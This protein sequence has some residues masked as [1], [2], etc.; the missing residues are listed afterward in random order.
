MSQA[1]DREVLGDWS[2]LKGSRYHLVYALWL[3]LRDRASGVHFFEGNDLLA[4][5]VVPPM[6]TDG[7]PP[8]AIPLVAAAGAEDLWIQLKCTRE[9]WTVTNLLGENL[10]FNFVC[11]SFL[12]E[13]R[14][15]SWRVLLVTEGVVRRDEI[16]DF[17]DNPGSRPTLNGRLEEVV[18]KASGALSDPGWQS[19]TAAEIRDR[20]VGILRHLA[21]TEPLALDTL[22]A[23][24]QIELT[25]ACPDRQRTRRLAS[26]LIGAMLEDAS[27]EPARARTY[28]ASWVN[29][30]A[31][32]AIKSAK[33]F[34]TDVVA[35][36]QLAAEDAAE[37]A[38]GTPHDESRHVPRDAA[39][40]RLRQFLS[41]QEV[42][43]LL[44][45]PSGAGKSATLAHWAVTGLAGRTRMLLKGS[46]L[47]P[48]TT[49]ARL[50][51]GYFAPYTD[52]E[53]RDVEFLRKIAE[54]SR[55]PGRGP[56]IVVVDDLSA[57]ELDD[58][59][60]W[61]TVADLA[62]A[63]GRVGGKLV[64]SCETQAWRL[65]HPW[66]RIPQGTLFDPERSLGEPPTNR[67]YE[68]G[69]LTPGELVEILS[70]RSGPASERQARR[71]ARLLLGPGHVPLRNP[72]L[73]TRYLELHGDELLS[74]SGPPG[75]VDI[76][77]LL[78][79]VVHVR[80]ERCA[81]MLRTDDATLESAFLGLVDRLWE[82]RVVG[83]T[84]SEAVNLLDERLPDDGKHALIAFRRHGLLASDSPI[85]ILDGAIADYLFATRLEGRI[86]EGFA[87]LSELDPERD[88]TVVEALT[89]RTLTLLGA[90]RGPHGPGRPSQR[91]DR[92]GARPAGSRRDEPR[93][94]GLARPPGREPPPG[95]RW[96]RG[97]RD[98][99]REGPTG[100]PDC[101]QHVPRCRSG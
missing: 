97:P 11:N 72:Y 53:W 2:N 100:V 8:P 13:A 86:R 68:L 7:T 76:D 34:D 78:E 83:V 26:L 45:G 23:E 39:L 9:P 28:D 88:A 94:G 48:G 5:P 74:R 69:V 14:G 36:C 32:T 30:V 57:D 41:A 24:V 62:D 98:A 58:R 61:S 54:I 4:R 93:P 3:I 27:E 10:L 31:G 89:R 101:H 96:L 17:A 80:L 6:L 50:V 95:H 87:R 70:R 38:L 12:S 67:S 43:F 75:P 49:L 92:E 42:V 90:R 16:L 99:G 82:R 20:A 51:A 84:H 44:I 15:R 35:A 65:H 59:R 1:I 85:R 52:R 21:D 29:D 73:L 79:A 46:S 60:G 77:R 18:T 63:V 22:R 19:P 40:R 56:L 33:P 81:A 55:E 64:I 37:R 91:P 66:L 47:E 71:R 25:L